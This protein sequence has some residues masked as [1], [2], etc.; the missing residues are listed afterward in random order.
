MQKRQNKFAVSEKQTPK[1]QF[2]K[3][4]KQDYK[5]MCMCRL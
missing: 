5:M 2:L 3:I 4:K 1:K